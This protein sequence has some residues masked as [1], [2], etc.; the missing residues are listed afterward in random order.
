M[1]GLTCRKNKPACCSCLR[2]Y[3]NYVFFNGMRENRARDW[4]EWT[5]R[6]DAR[7]TYSCGYGS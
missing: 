2:G 3:T 5:T 1:R 6:T 7:G 4:D